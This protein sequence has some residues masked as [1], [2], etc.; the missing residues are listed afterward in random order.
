M[1]VCNYQHVT[2]N[3]DKMHFTLTFIPNMLLSKFPGGV[4]MVIFFQFVITSYTQKDSRTKHFSINEG[5][6]IVEIAFANMLYND[7]NVFL[8]PLMVLL[9]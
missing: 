6:I 5:E 1:H 7:F 4:E 9:K 2:N 8:H 3:Y